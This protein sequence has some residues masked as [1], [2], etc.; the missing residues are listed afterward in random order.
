VVAMTGDGVNDAPALREAHI[1][2]AMGKTGTEVTREASDM[3]LAD[4]NFASMVSA[5]REGRGIFDN[6]RKSLTYLLSGNTGEL[7]VM[8]GAA[9]VGLP[10][11]LIPLQILWINLITDGLPAL[12][13]VMDPPDHD[14]LDR[15]P[16]R[17]EEPMLGRAEW[18]AILIIGAVQAA[19]TLGV[20]VWGLEH[21]QLPQA[22]SLAFSTLVFGPLF[23]AF[24]FRSRRCV[25]WEVGAFTNVLL[26]SVVV[27]SVAMQF[28]L[29]SIP[30]TQAL[31]RV[32]S[33]SLQDWALA[34][35]L[36]LAPVTV[37]EV[38]KLIR[39][40]RKSFR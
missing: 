24:A 37:V 5:V 8:L 15:P 23:L 10:L 35:L 26:V 2:V 21:R 28:M 11:P 18:T 17:L 25:L 29:V 13:L 14:V 34:I 20:F 12:A 32:G 7:G 30:A 3:V 27:L 9:I 33:L 19:V 39:R 22:R 31:F 40:R 1:G 36:G 6:I 38:N 4:D 16:R